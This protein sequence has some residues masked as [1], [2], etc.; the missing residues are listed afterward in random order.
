[1]ARIFSNGPLRDFVFNPF[2]AMVQN[3]TDLYIAAPYVTET[4]DLVE[5]AQAGKSVW[6]LVGLNTTTSPKALSAVHNRP[7]C[8]VRYFTNKFHAKIY[9]FDKTALVGSSNL[10]D[11]GLRSNRE[12]TI[13][14]DRSDDLDEL[15]GLFNELWESAT[16]LTD[17]KLKKFTA[18]YESMKS[19]SD[20]LQSRLEDAVGK[21]EPT[22]IAVGSGRKT[23]Q[24]LFVEQ[25][26][27]L[28]YEQYRPAFNEVT[29]VLKD[30]QLHRD[31][32]A[33]V[34]TASET[35]RFLNWVRLTHAPG[36]EW[37][38]APVL[39]V[40][41]RQARILALGREWT[42]TADNKIPEGYTEWLQRVRSTFGTRNTIADASKDQLTEA[43]TAIHA[44]YEQLRFVKGGI[45]NL[46]SE[47]WSAN[48]NDV[49]KAKRTFTH[50]LHGSGDFIERLHAILYDAAM[51]LRYFGMFCGLEL[52][53]TVKPEE[54]PPINGRMAKSLRYLGFDVKGD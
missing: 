20:L 7:N 5:A 32:L 18:A 17:D 53:G 13:W 25:L 34:G 45:A 47:F 27:R 30:N 33:D 36:D 22:N 10:T 38:L 16:V 40:A 3:S 24:G 15:R 52:V 6:L 54:F 50:L 26:H 21:S 37:R 49:P 23:S 48:D 51:K 4:G 43:L 12:A 2:K 11:G 28:L 9:L 31:E 1:M 39:P 44:F 14:V 41:D 29:R 46:G 19:P 42:Q 8:A 35:N